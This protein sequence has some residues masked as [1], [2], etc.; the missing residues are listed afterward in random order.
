MSTR[1][2]DK[3]GYAEASQSS[4]H[5]DLHRAVRGASAFPAGETGNVRRGICGKSWF[6]R[7]YGLSVGAGETRP[8]F[9]QNTGDCRVFRLQKNTGRSSRKIIQRKLLQFNNPPIDRNYAYAIISHVQN[10]VCS[11]T[12]KNEKS[13]LALLL[14]ARWFGHLTERVFH[15]HP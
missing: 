10:N 15:V 14:H 3:I 4:G 2:A 6:E 11:R 8:I 12:P 1:Y 7:N 9:R 5:V 13:A